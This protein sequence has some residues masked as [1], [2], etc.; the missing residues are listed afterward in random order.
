MSLGNP[1]Q[2][3]ENEQKNVFYVL[4]E[5]PIFKLIWILRIILKN[6]YLLFVRFSDFL[7]KFP[8]SNML[9][10]NRPVLFSKFTNLDKIKTKKRLSK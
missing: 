1:N 7:Y 2:N 3:P 9:F 8:V 10:K 4:F 5:F 6:M